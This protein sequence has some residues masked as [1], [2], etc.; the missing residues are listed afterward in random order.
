MAL[1]LMSVSDEHFINKSLDEEQKPSSDYGSSA[2]FTKGGGVQKYT[3]QEM[4]KFLNRVL[5]RNK[6]LFVFNSKLNVGTDYT[7]D[8]NTPSFS[9]IALIEK[10]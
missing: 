5:D 2:S 7:G 9:M 4:L 1:M 8:T 10:N 6:P 3:K